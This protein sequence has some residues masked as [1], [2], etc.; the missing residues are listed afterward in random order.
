M[1]S[2]RC[3]TKH[4]GI[5]RAK[6]QRHLIQSRWPKS[7]LDRA[8][9]GLEKSAGKVGRR[10]GLHTSSPHKTKDHH[11]GREMPPGL[12][13]EG[14]AKHARG[15]RVERNNDKIAVEKS[16]R[17]WDELPHECDGYIGTDNSPDGSCSRGDAGPKTI[18]ARG[19]VIVLS[20]VVA[21]P[22]DE[23]REERRCQET[24]GL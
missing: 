9:H 3:L 16:P 6:S 13:A 7:C 21:Q 12:M 11:V 17:G 18:F 1:S 19:R 8:H 20:E 2:P 5:A 23:Q 24:L 15:T 14:A 22:Y 10:S 4:C